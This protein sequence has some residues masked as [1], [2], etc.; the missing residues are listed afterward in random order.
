MRNKGRQHGRLIKMIKALHRNKMQGFSASGK[1]DKPGSCPGV[2]S[3]DDCPS[4]CPY[5]LAPG[6]FAPNIA[7]SQRQAAGIS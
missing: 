2:F 6:M 5:L 1:I 4:G 3:K 7:L